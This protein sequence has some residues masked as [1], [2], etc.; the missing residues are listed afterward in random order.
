[1]ASAMVLHGG[2]RHVGYLSLDQI[3]YVGKLQIITQVP[4]AL[5][6]MLG[7]ISVALFIM[8]ISGRTS[9]WRR[10]FIIIHI[11]IYTICTILNICI[12]MGQCRPVQALWDQSLKLSGKAKCIDP[13][14]DTDITLLQSCKVHRLPTPPSHPLTQPSQP[15]AHT[16]T[17]S[18]PS[19]H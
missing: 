16:S 9:K 17:L 5:S 2:A 12:L 13:S 19:S 18:S 7:K 6:A 8:R 14:I 4:A 15:L 11:T 10:W 1:M 3:L